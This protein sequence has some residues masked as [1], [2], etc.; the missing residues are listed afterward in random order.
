MP[1]IPSTTTQPPRYDAQ[2]GEWGSLPQEPC[3]YCRRQGGVQFLI[4]NGPEGRTS[5]QI[6]RC[7]LCGRDW[8]ADSA[9]A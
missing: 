2:T 5:A 3:R 9:M 7:A 4:D 1:E 6:V 8:L